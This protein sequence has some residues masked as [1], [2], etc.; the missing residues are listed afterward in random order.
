MTL[1]VPEIIAPAD[2]EKTIRQYRCAQAQSE[3]GEVS[4]VFLCITNR[5]IIQYAST[6]SGNK[7]TTL[8][9]DVH[10]NEVS[11]TSLF[12]GKE[13]K[14][15]KFQKILLIC[16]LSA[17]AIAAALCIFG[18]KIG[19]L[20][21]M[22]GVG[23]YAILALVPFAIAGILILILRGRC[24]DV[25]MSIQIMT[26]NMAVSSVSVD[27]GFTANAPKFISVIPY[28]KELKR[29][30]SELSSLILDV[31]HYGPDEVLRRVSVEEDIDNDVA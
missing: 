17:F 28:P 13:Y 24:F 7:T 22:S 25:V 11:G 19:D 4:D 6:G 31:Q 14:P 16:L 12:R 2:N 8:Y 30:F 1:I 9:N 23:L 29:L 18:G 20:I 15:K 10:M 3:S 5:R 26:R 21:G 27:A